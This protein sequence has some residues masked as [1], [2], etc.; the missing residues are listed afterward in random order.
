MY[1]RFLCCVNQS[2]KKKEVAHWFTSYVWLNLN[3][4]KSVVKIAISFDKV[5]YLKNISY[6]NG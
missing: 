5:L 2:N 1:F 6:H 4:Q 3:L